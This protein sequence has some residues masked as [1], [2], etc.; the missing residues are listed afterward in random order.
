MGS[1]LFALMVYTQLLNILK[2]KPFLKKLIYMYIWLS[3]G[4]N[5]YID[6]TVNMCTHKNKNSLTITPTNHESLDSNVK[7][8]DKSMESGIVEAVFYYF[9]TTAHQRWIITDSLI[10]DILCI[11][12]YLL[13]TS[14]ICCHCFCISSPEK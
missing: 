7:V 2:G 8:S 1:L 6:I 4:W 10:V 12:H 9:I 11:Y 5:K 14:K 13:L 3:K